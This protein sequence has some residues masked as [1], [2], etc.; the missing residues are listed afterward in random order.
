[1]DFF[2]E[3]VHFRDFYHFAIENGLID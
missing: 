1:M 2:F 3:K